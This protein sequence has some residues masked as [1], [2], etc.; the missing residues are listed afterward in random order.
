MPKAEDLDD[1]GLL[2]LMDRPFWLG[3]A[4]KG[5]QPRVIRSVLAMPHTTSWH[6]FLKLAVPLDG[7]DAK[8]VTAWKRALDVVLGLQADYAWGSKQKKAKLAAVVADP[9]MLA[10]V[11]GTVAHAE[12]ARIDLLAVLVID[13][14]KESL[15][16]L[17]GH[18]ERA[19]EAEDRRLD[20]LRR[21]RKHA[22]STPEL[23]ALFAEV[24]GKL[25]ERA[26]SSPALALGPVIGIGEV[27]LL[28]FR[29]SLGSQ[30][31]TPGNVPR[32]QGNVNVDSRSPMWL[33][34]SMSRLDDGLTLTSTW[35]NDK[36]LQND[37]LGLGGCEVA[38]LPDWLARAAKTL[39]IRA[40]H[41]QQPARQATR[42]RPRV[43]VPDQPHL[44]S[45]HSEH[46]EPREATTGGLAILLRDPP[47]I[48][49][50]Q[51]GVVGGAVEAPDRAALA[52][53]RQ[54]P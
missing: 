22:R 44:G 13:A 35:L 40:A 29:V 38:T 52:L 4:G 24:D 6:L 41:L 54:R 53:L 17:V 42:P 37:A 45:R 23:D 3:K 2:G 28:W 50:D 33:S 5:T 7:N 39:A 36:G 46:L 9:A 19:V 21:L 8:L 18:F 1:A 12:D 30:Q 27:D 43:V 15:D 25:E 47:E 10:A 32:V 16:A 26:A 31:L 34:V 14:S 49:P 51:R 11:Q 20:R 48:V